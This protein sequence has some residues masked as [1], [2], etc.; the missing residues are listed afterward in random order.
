MFSKTKAGYKYISKGFTKESTVQDFPIR[1]K[2]LYLHLR[3]R[4]WLEQ[5]TG[6]IIS[7]SYDLSTSGARLSK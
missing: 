7:S 6:N 2:A 1:G 3:K 5:E 4:K